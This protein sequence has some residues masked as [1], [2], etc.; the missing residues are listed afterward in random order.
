M[1]TTVTVPGA[2]G[3]T[4]PNHYGTP[5]NLEVAQQ[6]SSLLAAADADSA[7]FIQGSDQNPAPVPPGDL[8]MIAVTVPGGV[9]ADVPAGYSVTTIDGTVSGP[10]TINGGGS[11]FAGDQTISYFGAPAAATVLIAAG[12]GKDLIAMPHGSTYDIA[13]GGGNDTVVADGSG[14]VSGGTGPNIVFS[15]SPGGENVINSYGDADTIV[16]GQGAVTVNAHGADPLVYGG[17]GQLVYMGGA[18]GSPTVAGGTGRETLYAGPGQDLTYLDGSNTA[19]GAN[20]LAAGAGNETLDASGAQHGVDLAAGCGSVD[21]IGSHGNDVFFGGSGAATMTGGGGSDAFV[22]GNT[23][24]HT[25]GTDIITDFGGTDNF[26]LVG[27]G[28]AAAQTALN[29]ATVAGGN[30]M[31]KLSD[32]TTITFLGVSNPAG[33]RNQAF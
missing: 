21:L 22:F 16:A 32:N 18:P 19:T 5:Y 23:A 13:P 10:V 25:G 26:V 33:I 30:T 31:V 1:A 27:Y 7:L 11:L 14:T 12:D 15:D 28:A 29:A 3:A 8:G 9:V 24:G 4:D 20:I 6:I 17:S 2:S